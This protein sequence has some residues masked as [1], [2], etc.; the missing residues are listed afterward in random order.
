MVSHYHK[1]FMCLVFTYIIIT[2]V[3][4]ENKSK[5]VKWIIFL[6]I[7]FLPRGRVTKK[8]PKK[9]NIYQL[10]HL[11]K[12][13]LDITVTLIETLC[14]ILIGPCL[15]F[16]YLSSRGNP[17]YFLY[18]AFIICIVYL[19]LFKYIYIHFLDKNNGIFSLLISLTMRRKFIRMYW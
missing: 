12:I 18:Q 17:S 7:I 14:L 5:M 8:L 10:L 13:M 6:Y 11:K 3:E 16:L 4:L 19:Y 1:I 15:C 2:V 9:I